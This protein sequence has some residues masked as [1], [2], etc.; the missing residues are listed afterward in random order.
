M[1]MAV[2]YGQLLA[3]AYHAPILSP[4]S[5]PLAAPAYGASWITTDNAYLPATSILYKK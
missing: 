5:A 3:P 4:W 2:A 1:L